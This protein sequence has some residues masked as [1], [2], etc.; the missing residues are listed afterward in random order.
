MK[1]NNKYTSNEI[2]ILVFYFIFFL[3]NK[4]QALHNPV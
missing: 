1:E 3:G 2:R 4:I